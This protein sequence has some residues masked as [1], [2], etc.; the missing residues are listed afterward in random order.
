MEGALVIF[1][2]IIN[3]QNF[4]KTLDQASSVDDA[5]TRRRPVDD[6]HAVAGFAVNAIE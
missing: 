1:I 6:R 5:R 4:C 2:A 3:R